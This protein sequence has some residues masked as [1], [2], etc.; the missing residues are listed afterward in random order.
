MLISKRNIIKNKWSDAKNNSIYVLYILEKR[1][2][3][4]FIYFNKKHRNLLHLQINMALK[5]AQ[6]MGSPILHP[7]YMA[8]N[9]ALNNIDLKEQSV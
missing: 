8:T 6:Y 1:K 2:A 3:E 7:I 9:I 5:C 4:V